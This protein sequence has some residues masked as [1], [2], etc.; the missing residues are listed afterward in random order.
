MLCSVSSKWRLY[1]EAASFHWN[2]G[3]AEQALT[4][5]VQEATA[6][7]EATAVQGSNQHILVSGWRKLKVIAGNDHASIRSTCKDTRCVVNQSSALLSCP[8]KSVL[9]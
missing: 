9:S 7:R 4:T 5:Q 3:E 2:A 1:L 8:C 6:F